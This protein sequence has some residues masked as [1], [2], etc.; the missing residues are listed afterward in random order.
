MCTSVMLGEAIG[1]GERS[2]SPTVLELTLE[3]LI[4]DP[5]KVHVH[6]L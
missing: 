6:G 1:F 4:M 5:A 3:H 2:F